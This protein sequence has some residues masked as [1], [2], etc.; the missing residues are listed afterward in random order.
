MFKT[1]KIFSSFSVDDLGN[2]R[3]FY[4]DVSGL[5]VAEMK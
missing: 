4:T 2:A 5:D 3:E 1:S